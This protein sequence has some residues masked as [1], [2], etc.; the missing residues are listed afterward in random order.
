MVL[1]LLKQRSPKS[2]LYGILLPTLTIFISRVHLSIHNY[3]H[4][5]ETHFEFQTRHNPHHLKDSKQRSQFQKWQSKKSKQAEFFT[6]L[7][8]PSN[9]KENQRLHLGKFSQGS[10]EHTR[11]KSTDRFWVSRKKASQLDTP[12]ATK[13]PQQQC[14]S[15]SRSIANINFY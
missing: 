9:C 4:I 3:I 6:T 2:I 1:H 5:L 11:T 14:F 10:Q 7:F 12:S 8:S 15:S 13:H